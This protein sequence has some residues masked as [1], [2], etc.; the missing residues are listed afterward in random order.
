MKLSIIIVNYNVKYFLEQCLLSVHDAIKNIDAEVFVVDNHSHDESVQ[1]VQ[2]KFPWVHC[3]AN[4]KNTGFSVA[5][6]Q[7]IHL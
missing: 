7:A 4:E 5:N 1:M 2:E 3:I 6:N